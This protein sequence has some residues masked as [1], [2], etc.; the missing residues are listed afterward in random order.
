M[1]EKLNVIR[2]KF[3]WGE[4]E[5]LFVFSV[6]VKV[7]KAADN[8]SIQ[9]HPTDEVAKQFGREEGKSEFWYILK[10][11]EDASIY[12]GFNKHMSKD[13][14][15]ASLEDNSIC[16]HINKISVKAGDGFW[17]PA[18]LVHAILKGVTLLEVQN[19]VDLTY[20]FYDYGR[21][22]LDGNPRELHI[23]ESLASADMQATQLP[24]QSDK[25]LVNGFNERELIKTS[26]FA[27]KEIEGSGS[28]T[29][30]A[31]KCNVFVYDVNKKAYYS[32][33]KG[34]ELA[35]SGD[36]KLIKVKCF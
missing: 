36:I 1:I 14:I 31:K 8:L 24:V 15:V 35:F 10:A 7:I 20:R 21:V 13:A 26:L 33:K 11:D 22:G 18:G 25:V 32:V 23:E 19:P 9:V 16:D 27:M 12:F 4:T 2:N 3:I 6:L 28:Y 30:T 29:V 17:V 34:K 5:E